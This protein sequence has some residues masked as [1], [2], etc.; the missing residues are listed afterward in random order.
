MTTERNHTPVHD[1]DNYQYK[2]RESGRSHS[3]YEQ[4]GYPH[5]SHQDFRN[6]SQIIPQQNMRKESNVSL[7][8]FCQ[9]PVFK[10]SV[11]HN[12]DDDGEPYYG[13]FIIHF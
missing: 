6:P 9:Q 13:M 11:L 1:M 10:D 4:L 2:V 5:N 8:N 12:N 3:E 7:E